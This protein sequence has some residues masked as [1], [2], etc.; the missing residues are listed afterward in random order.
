AYYISLSSSISRPSFLSGAASWQANRSAKVKMNP[1]AQACV[2]A[3]DPHVSS[4]V[5]LQGSTNVS[6]SSCV[7]AANSDASDAV[8]RGGS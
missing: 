7:I 3:L 8:S 6:M 1:G 5:S 4:A 2:L